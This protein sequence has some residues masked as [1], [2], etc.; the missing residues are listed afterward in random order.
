MT[1]DGVKRQVDLQMAVRT[2]WPTATVTGNNNRAGLSAAS[3]D[4]L[5]T[6]VKAEHA[7]WPT[8]R[9]HQSAGCHETQW[10]PGKK[11][12][13][14]GKPISTSLTDQVRIAET[15]PTESARD[16]RDGRASEETMQRNSRPL[17]ETVVNWPSPHANCATG[18]GTQGRDGGANIQTA[19]RQSPGKGHRA[20]AQLNPNWVTQLQGYP[21]DWLDSLEAVKNPKRSK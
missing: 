20:A 21:D 15:W 3:G 5:A 12:T 10:E 7:E 2:E 19:V 9:A 4:G 6:A 17:N 1:V 18:A 16:Y 8:P 11:P 14:N 13:L